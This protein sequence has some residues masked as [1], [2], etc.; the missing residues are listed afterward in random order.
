M[1]RETIAV[2]VQEL[3]DQAI[4]TAASLGDFMTEPSVGPAQSAGPFR[5]LAQTNIISIIRR[6]VV[7]LIM[8]S[9]TQWEESLGRCVRGD[10]L[11][12]GRKAARE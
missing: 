5:N 3:T 11:I 10:R 6:C 9:S 1:L 8:Q 4:V 2:K 7:I 12:G